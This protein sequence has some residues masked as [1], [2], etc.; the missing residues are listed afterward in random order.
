M[1]NT[2]E[3]VSNR[4]SFVADVSA[5]ASRAIRSLTR[6]PEFIGP[7]LAIPIFFFVVNIG[8]LEAFVER[9]PGIDYR[10]FQLPV[11]IVFAVTGISRANMLVIDIQ[12]GYLDRMLVTPIRRTALLL[13][14]MIADIVLALA[15]ATVVLVLGFVVGGGFET[16]VPGL[17]A[18]LALSMAWSLAFTGFPY[19]V[20]LRTGNPAAVNSAFLIFFPFA[21]LTPS[22]LP[23]DLMSGW[24]KTVSAWNPVTYLLEGMRSVISAGWDLSMILKA[25]AA[26][27]GLGMVTFTMAF[28]S[29]SKRV[30]TG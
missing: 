26:I 30:A 27:V 22:M 4:N 10:A 3:T 9:Q 17:M 7:A 11:A 2:A 20:A 15:L 25:V 24:L 23:R 28:R 18:F 8:A 16:G 6:E 21:F 1:R 5:V 12:T 19:T 29:L 13:G 14:L